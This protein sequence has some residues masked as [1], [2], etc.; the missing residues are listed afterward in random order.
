MLPIF[1]ADNHY[2][3]ALDCCTRHI[4]PRLR[5]RAVRYEQRDGKHLIFVGERL[6]TY[7]AVYVDHCGTPGSL[8]RFLRSLKAGV[9]GMHSEGDQALPP[10]YRERDRRLAL[11][12]AQGVEAALLLPSLGVTLEHFMKDDAAQ[13]CANLRAFNRWL[14]ED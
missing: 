14:D 7:G 13:T 2:Y 8:V 6:Y 10:E 11:M 5:A 4:E 12:D 9:E 1:D 3:E